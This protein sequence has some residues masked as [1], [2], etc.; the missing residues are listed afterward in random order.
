[1]P[2]RV[3]TSSKQEPTA[4]SRP[5]VTGVLQRKCACG[6][7]SGPTGECE[8][9]RKKRLQ[10]KAAN[11]AEAPGEVPSIVHDVLRSPGQPLDPG[12]RVFFEP[13]FGHDFSRVRVHTD[14]AAAESARAVNAMAYTV[15][16]DIVFGSVQYQPSTPDGR[17][18]LAHEL[19]HVV[20]Q[21][22]ATG[23]AHLLIQ[24][25]NHPSEREAQ[26]SAAA[27]EHGSTPHPGARS[28]SVVARRVGTPAGVMPSPGT[29][30]PQGAPRYAPPSPSEDFYQMYERAKQRGELVGDPDRIAFLLERPVASL[31]RGGQP[32]DF[33]T[34]LPSVR[35]TY[36]PPRGGK[37]A[38]T[39]RP[40]KFHILDAIDD[41][42]AK[43]KSVE[44]LEA[45]RQKFVDPNANVFRGFIVPDGLDPGGKQRTQTYI[46]ALKRLERAL[47]PPQPPVPSQPG[48]PPSPSPDPAPLPATPNAPQKPQTAPAP[49]PAPQLQ[50]QPQPATQAPSRVQPAP[51]GKHAGCRH[52]WA[53][54]NRPNIIAMQY[55]E[56]A[57]LRPAAFKGQEYVVDSGK[58]QAEFDSLH[59]GVL[60]ECKCGYES[61]ARA[62][63]M[64]RSTGESRYR[65]A[66]R[67]VW[68]GSESKDPKK[69]DREPISAQLLR[70]ANV[71]RDC[72]F[73]FRL[74]VSNQDSADM[75]AEV[76]GKGGHP[77]TIAVV[78]DPTC[79]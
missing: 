6:G 51:P 44:E 18:L 28:Q 35:T 31:D 59:G 12:A 40:H 30:V 11:H 56:D 25:E 8:E 24:P 52:G 69:Q 32:P 67:A 19:T 7:A 72:G 74:Y 38:V 79:D 66:Y 64:W 61:T 62:Y 13:R 9:C 14:S 27:I 58:E 41:A 21:Y 77:S 48:P 78:P 36:T 16:Q 54:R 26:D 1:M 2:Q 3:S 63:M 45:V 39:Y 65:W 70:E 10:R 68:E 71:A 4:T 49:Q 43:A 37:F 17:R 20:Q 57:T 5:R 60:Y 47:Q 55:C 73:M 33:I 46:D 76:L 15:G 42:V 50:G 53:R 34:V 22:A 75:F 23:A 29:L